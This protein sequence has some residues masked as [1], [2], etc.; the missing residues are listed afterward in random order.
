MIKQPKANNSGDPLPHG[1]L[2]GKR[3]IIVTRL[4]MLPQ[5]HTVQ[6]VLT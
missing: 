5:N 4:V 2:E 1:I 3:K 6:Q